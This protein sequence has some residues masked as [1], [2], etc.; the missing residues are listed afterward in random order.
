M[1]INNNLKLVIIIIIYRIAGIHIILSYN[2][3]TYLK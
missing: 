3:I 1:R 2:Y